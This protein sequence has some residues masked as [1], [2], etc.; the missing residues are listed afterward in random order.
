MK[1]FIFVLIFSFSSCGLLSE[2]VKEVNYTSEEY[3]KFKPSVA[4]NY[5]LFKSWAVHPKKENI[6][7]EEFI[8]NEEL[9]DVNVFFIHPT[10]FWDKKNTAW[11][12]DINDIDMAESINSSSI[13]YQ[14][15][16]WASTGNLYAPLYR[17][18][19]LRV[20]KESFWFNGGKEAYELAYSDIK[21]AFQVFLNKY[22]NDKPIIIAG[23]SQGAGH[24]KRILQDFFDGK[25]LQNKLIAAY[26]VGT[27]VTKDDFRYIKPMVH[28]NETGG[29]VSWNT[30]RKV[31]KKKQARY[32][33]TV[34]YEWLEGAIC[35]N[36]ITWDEKKTSEYDEHK[37]FLY[38]NKKIY[39][40]T[41][42]IENIDSKVYINIPKMNILKKI[43]LS[44][45]KDYHKADINLFWE[46]IRI[47]SIN[48]A[49]NYLSKTY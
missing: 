8:N 38:I 36:P 14:A 26:L 1:Y 13:K 18:A 16:A 48:R 27:K 43:L 6:I 37:G 35:S 5:E 3:G 49:K 4:P 40:K 21:N 15:S 9:L 7:I 46:D 22:N 17:Q 29:F 11:N 44:S 31:S 39:P 23:H 2:S 34:N 47:N 42:K 41:V 45:V 10:L 19:H 25:P 12:S 30:F 33:Y 20:F 24:A 32:S 28:K